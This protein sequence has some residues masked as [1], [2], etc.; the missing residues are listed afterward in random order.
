MALKFVSPASLLPELFLLRPLP[1]TFTDLATQEDCGDWPRCE[2]PPSIHGHWRLLGQAPNLA[3]LCLCQELPTTLLN[4]PPS[5]PLPVTP[6]FSL[7]GSGRLFTSRSPLSS[8]PHSAILVL[9][10]LS[11]LGLNLPCNINGPVRSAGYQ[12]SSNVPLLTR[13]CQLECPPTGCCDVSSSDGEEPARCV[14]VC[15]GVTE[16]GEARPQFSQPPSLS[17]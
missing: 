6:S 5:S 4:P 8:L 15:A 10:D 13:Q 3:S 16:E 14:C 1:A 9:L 2:A 17:L 7:V 11:E 12:L